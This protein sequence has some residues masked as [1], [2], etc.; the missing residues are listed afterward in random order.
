[1]KIYTSEVKL[2]KHI[3]DRL[4]TYNYTWIET[5]SDRVIIDNRLKSVRS[6]RFK[7]KLTKDIIK[8]YVYPVYCYIPYF[9]YSITGT[10][11]I[12]DLG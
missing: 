11:E 4:R 7:S 6:Y 10:N 1:M 5:S 12:I 8:I 3:I 2:N 9:D